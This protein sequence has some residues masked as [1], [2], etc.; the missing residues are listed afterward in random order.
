M[1]SKLTASWFL[2]L[3]WVRE[4]MRLLPTVVRKIIGTPEFSPLD[5]TVNKSCNIE[6]CAAVVRKCIKLLQI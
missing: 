4:F 2:P 6:R 5:P 1:D 3:F